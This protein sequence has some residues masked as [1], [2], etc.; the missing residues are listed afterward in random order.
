M[1]NDKFIDISEIEYSYFMG[2]IGSLVS[3]Y[4]EKGLYLL[5]T[6]REYIP[7]GEY[8]LVFND[9]Y[10]D[11]EVNEEANGWDIINEIKT[12]FKESK[13]ETYTF[14]NPNTGNKIIALWVMT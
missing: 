14:I 4:K 5:F 2:E 3:N 9:E 8:E 6:V 12:Y 7:D 10:D 1:K 11:Y 13:I